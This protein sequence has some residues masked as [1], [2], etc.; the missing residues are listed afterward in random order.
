MSRG[1]DIAIE[2]N[3]T[4]HDLPWTGATELDLV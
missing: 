3:L 1:E 4:G 2:E